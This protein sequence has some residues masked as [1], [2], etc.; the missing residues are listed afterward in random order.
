MAKEGQQLPDNN[1][2]PT[3]IQE[4]QPEKTLP[5]KLNSLPGRNLMNG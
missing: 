3:Q 2:E 4:P 1:A 5:E